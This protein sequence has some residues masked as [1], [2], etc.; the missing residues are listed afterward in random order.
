MPMSEGLYYKHSGKFPLSALLAGL[1]VGVAVG[2]P[3]AYAY[4]Y[5]II[6]VPIVYLSFLLSMGFGL[7]VGLATAGGLRMRKAR[8]TALSAVLSLLV[9]LGCLYFSWGVWV[10]AN[11]RQ[12][13]IKDIGLL[14][15]VL[16][17][18]SLW[19]LILEMNKTGVW[20]IR[21]ATPTG[22]TLWVVWGVEAAVILGCVLLAAVAIIQSD[23]FCEN[24]EKW[25]EKKEGVGRANSGDVNELKQRM[26]SKDFGYLEKLGTAGVEEPAWFRVDLHSCPS[27][28][29]TNTLTVKSITVSVDKRGK[30]SEKS[31]DVVDK[32]LIS[33]SEADAI[34]RFG[35]K[36]TSG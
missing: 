10:Y 11:L 14:G 7:L 9:G 30:R 4:S 22:I 2:L 31:T 35:Q 25:C 5:A 26:E 6:Y 27:C 36:P 18:D 1:L 34:R 29:A 33:A 21:G 19:R 3:G 15:L 8:N 32:L 23:P 16:R 28:Q 13:G 20:T 24:C 17:P 12:A